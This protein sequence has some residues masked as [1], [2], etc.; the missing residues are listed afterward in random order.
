MGRKKKKRKSTDLRREL[1][2]LLNSH[3]REQNSSTPDFILARYLIGCLEAFEQAV[4]ARDGWY[5]SNHLPFDP[6]RPSGDA[7]AGRH[8]QPVIA[9]ST[10]RS[11]DRERWLKAVENSPEV[12]H[13]EWTSGVV[14]PSDPRWLE[15][16]QEDPPN[17][18]QDGGQE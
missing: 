2:A 13:S 7:P 12:T 14:Y 9:I 10:G 8:P 17:A 1:A 15:T 6:A 4:N 16:A 11:S 3:S 18:V 5:F